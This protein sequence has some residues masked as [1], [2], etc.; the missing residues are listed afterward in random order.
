MND[1]YKYSINLSNK[2][3]RQNTKA[4]KERFNKITQEELSQVTSR[5]ELARL[6]GYTDKNMSAGVSFIT[7]L[8]AKKKLIEEFSSRD[9]QRVINN[10]FFPSADNRNHE[11]IKNVKKKPFAVWFY[12]E[13]G[14]EYTA[15]A[16]KC[17]VE[18]N[19]RSTAIKGLLTHFTSQI[20]NPEEEKKTPFSIE[21]DGIKITFEDFSSENLEKVIDILKK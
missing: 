17:G 18:S 2:K 1:T 9:G 8:I 6:C 13:Q 15:L 11:N 10:Y 7:R 3:K 21:K 5:R 12:E 16:E 4:L 20:L 14:N 19:N